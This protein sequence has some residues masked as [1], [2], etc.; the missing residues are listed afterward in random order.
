[1]DI[2]SWIK[3]ARLHAGLTQTQLGEPLDV[4]KGNVSAWEKGRHA[5]SFDQLVRIAEITRY[6]EPLPGMTGSPQ[7]TETPTPWPLPAIPRERIEALAKHPVKL[8]RLQG[9]FMLAIRLVE[10]GLSLPEEPT[11][12]KFPADTNSFAGPPPKT[13]TT[14]NEPVEE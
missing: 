3:A 7:P 6:Q 12:P 1:M 5:P 10:A 9:A 11:A 2:K 8:E 13:S 14:K 4:S